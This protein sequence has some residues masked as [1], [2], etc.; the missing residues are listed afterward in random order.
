M[1]DEKGQEIH[2][3]VAQYFTLL[4]NMAN[5]LPK[6][7]DWEID[8]TQHFWTHLTD[9]IR[10]Q[11]QS[12]GYSHISTANRRDPFNQL[13]DLQNAY[14]AATVAEDALNRY[15]RIAQDTFQSS[16][17]LATGVDGAPWVGT[18]VAEDT[19]AKYGDS[20][21]RPR[22][23]CWGC[24]SSDHSFANRKTITC[25][26]KDKPGVMDRAAKARKDFNDKLAAKKKAAKIK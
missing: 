25:P 3:S 9:N 15:Q 26:N 14:A 21:K 23:P 12:N 22:N 19:M 24:G 17:V 16:L 2:Q 18:S 5:F 10:V 20:N 7:Q 6:N 11:M 13:M 8:I 1:K 4:Q